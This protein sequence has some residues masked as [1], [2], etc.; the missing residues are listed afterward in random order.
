MPLKLVPPTPN[1]SPFWRVRGTYIGIRIDRSTKTSE[2]KVAAKLLAKWKEDIERGAYARPDDPTF[3]SAALAYMQAGGERRFIKPLLKYFGNRLLAEIGQTEIDNA[4]AA[5]YPNGSV[6]TRNRQVYSPISAILKRA[7]VEKAIKRPKGWRGRARPHWLSTE[8]AWAL[9]DA[10]KDTN[11]R[12]ASLLVFLFY[13]GPRLSEA[14]RLEWSDVDLGSAVAIL[15][16]TKNGEPQSCHLPPVV[17]AELAGME[18]KWKTVFGFSK[19][20]RLYALLAAAE[21]A[22]GVSIPPGVA[23]HVCRHSYGAWMRRHAG[24]DTSGL[25]A[26]GRWKDRSSAAVYEHVNT[27][28]EARR[29]DLLPT[30]V[31]VVRNRP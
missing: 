14:L 6:T 27:T 25:V 29:A 5:I 22:S 18:R 4:A 17:V 15:G 31:K 1:R 9:I 11:P 10:A 3:A 30:S 16:H 13:C 8:Q 23:F 28:E 19:A 21:K 24:L 20:G 7:G 12:F 26:T 2:R